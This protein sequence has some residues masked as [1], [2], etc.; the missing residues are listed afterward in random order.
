MARW[1]FRQ[2]QKTGGDGVDVTSSY[3]V[4]HNMQKCW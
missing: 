3:H 4:L 2:L 1:A